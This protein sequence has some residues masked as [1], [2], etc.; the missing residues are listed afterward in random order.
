MGVEVEG[1]SLLAR[2]EEGEGVPDELPAE[3][4]FLDAAFNCN[5]VIDLTG[6]IFFNVRD[7][8]GEEVSLCVA[9]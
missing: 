2:E 4:I 1:H 5:P 3:L 9:L 7:I 6:H 8:D